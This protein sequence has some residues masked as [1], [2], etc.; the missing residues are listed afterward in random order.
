[1][2]LFAATL[3]CQVV[4]EVAAMLGTDLD[5]VVT[6]RKPPASA[7]TAA[8]LADPPCRGPVTLRTLL[9]YFTDVLASPHRDALL[10]LA[11]V[12]TNPD[13]AARLSRLASPAGKEEYVA[14][15]GKV[16]R[17]LLEV[18]RDFP[19]AR[20]SLG[21]FFGGV[22][23]RLQPRFYSISSS[24]AL[25]AKSV[26]L[27]VAVVKDVMPTGRT[28]H[29]IASSWLQRCALTSGASVPVFVRHS[30][31]KLPKDPSTPVVMVGPGTGLAPFRGFLQE[32]AALQSSGAHNNA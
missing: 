13:E 2:L 3:L 6:L 9:S 11:S 10:A 29:G 26:H 32:R 7:P 5:T 16:H 30:H 12:A 17:S 25:H 4:Q 20:P 19:S 23:P 28:H 27:T 8:G 22:A 15:I 21:V 14:Y 1:M 31:F 24:P 18:M